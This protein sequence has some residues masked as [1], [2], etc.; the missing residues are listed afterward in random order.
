MKF[1]EI[2][3]PDQSAPI[4]RRIHQSDRPLTDRLLQQPLDFRWV[5]T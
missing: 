1:P 2:L 4:R 3:T 5:A